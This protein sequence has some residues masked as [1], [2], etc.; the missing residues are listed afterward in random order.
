MDF[1]TLVLFLGAAVSV[2]AAVFSVLF[3][4][5]NL[6]AELKSDVEELALVVDRLAK[7]Q[8]RDR[9][10]RVRQGERVGET[11]LAASQEPTEPPLDFADPK[12]RKAELRRR[13]LRSKM[14]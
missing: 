11:P 5:R 8:R 6:D 13:M 1:M 12:A 7:S 10:A 4:R 3:S 2:A 9:M 14:Q